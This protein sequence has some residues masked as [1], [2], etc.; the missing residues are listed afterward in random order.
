M[1]V[2]M[3]IPYFLQYYTDSVDVLEVS[4]NTIGECFKQLMKHYPQT[5]KWFAFRDGK[6][7]SD[8]AFF[9][10]LNGKSIYPIKLDIPTKDGD[11]ISMGLLIG[12]G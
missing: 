9:M 2:K 4:G 5:K 1:S 7:L 12:G 11:E 6:L 3:N 10:L 8:A